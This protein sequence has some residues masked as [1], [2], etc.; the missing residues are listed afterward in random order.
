MAIREDL[1]DNPWTTTLGHTIKYFFPY[2]MAT[3]T[4]KKGKLALVLNGV[5][6]VLNKA[7][8]KALKMCNDDE[9]LETRLLNDIDFILGYPKIDD[10][11]F[12]KVEDRPNT[13]ER[14]YI[15]IKPDGTA[16]AIM[17]A[18]TNPNQ[19]GPT[20][21]SMKNKM[22]EANLVK[23]LEEPERARP[24]LTVWNLHVNHLGHNQISQ[25]STSR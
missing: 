25:D 16:S 8:L 17:R 15:M 18:N 20:L 24:E 21:E 22:I 4:E 6:K 3:L 11:G 13:D 2:K 9:V 10:T 1:Q 14:G 12:I 7:Q 23:P 5:T 19:M